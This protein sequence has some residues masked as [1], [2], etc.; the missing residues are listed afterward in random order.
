MNGKYKVVCNAN[1]SSAPSHK[2][3]PRLGLYLFTLKKLDALLRPAVT[4]LLFFRQ[5]T[6]A[7]LAIYSGIFGIDMRRIVFCTISAPQLI[8]TNK[9]K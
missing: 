2:K 9:H 4:P 1:S 5:I 6:R 3:A 7:A 8:T